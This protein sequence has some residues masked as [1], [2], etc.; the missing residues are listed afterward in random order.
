MKSLSESAVLVWLC[1]CMGME[2]LQFVQCD[3]DEVEFWIA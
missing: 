1:L 3:A 2:G